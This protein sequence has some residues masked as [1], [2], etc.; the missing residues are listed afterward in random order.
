VIVNGVI[1]EDQ[2]AKDAAEFVLNRVAMQQ[3]HMQEI[4]QIFGERVRAVLPLFETEVKGAAM[5]NRLEG[6]LYGA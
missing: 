4:W 1:Q 2:V 5:L 3:E 6:R